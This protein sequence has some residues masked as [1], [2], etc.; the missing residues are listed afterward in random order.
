MLA[1]NKEWPFSL[2][3]QK[4]EVLQVDLID[5]LSLA[6]VIAFETRLSEIKKRGHC[7]VI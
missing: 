2:Y 6:E 3:V 7:Y 4:V 1:L 5:A